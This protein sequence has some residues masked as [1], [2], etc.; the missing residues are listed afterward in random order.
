MC[1]GAYGNVVGR[2]RILRRSEWPSRND[3][4]APS[5]FE[6][7]WTHKQ[8]RKPRTKGRHEGWKDGGKQ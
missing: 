1:Q 3:R 5:G 2:M 4:K 7:A 6:D 8:Q